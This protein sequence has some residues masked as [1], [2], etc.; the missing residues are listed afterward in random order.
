MGG[1]QKGCD[2]VVDVVVDGDEVRSMILRFV[3]SFNL[4]DGVELAIHSS[5]L[6]T[7]ATF[8]RG[9]D[10]YFRQAISDV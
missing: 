2:E 5:E 10:A 9:A 1:S 7:S 6:V 4:I 3:L 8:G